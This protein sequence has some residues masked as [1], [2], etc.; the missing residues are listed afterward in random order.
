LLK[1]F[2][3]EVMKGLK[4]PAQIVKPVIF[5]TRTIKI[6]KLLR[7]LREK[8]AHLAVVVDEHGGTLGIVTIEDILEELVGEIWDEHD[9]VVEPVKKDASGGFTVLGKVNFRDML[10]AVT[11]GIAHNDDEIPDTTVAN[12]IMENLGRLPAAGEELTWRYLTIRVTR[13]LRHR[14]MEVTVNGHFPKPGQTEGS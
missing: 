12:W 9:T 4:T 3:H 11:D 1:D 5:V 6:A 8:H 14:V 10:E 2:V 7:T 13:V